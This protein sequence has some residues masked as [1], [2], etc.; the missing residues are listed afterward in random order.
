MD[1]AREQSEALLDPSPAL[2]PIDER[3]LDRIDDGLHFG[4]S[5]HRYRY[6]YRRSDGLR[7]LDAGCGTG[8]SSLGL[9]RLN[10]GATVLG[11]DVEPAALEVARRRAEVAGV[12]DVAFRQHDLRQPLAGDDGPFDFVVCRRVLGRAEDPDRVLAHLARVLDA[13]GLLLLTLPAR[14][15][16]GPVH[17]LRQAIGAL[18]PAGAELAE[19]AAVGLELFAALRPDHP[20]RQF[21]ARFSGAGAPT[22]ARIIA[23]YLGPQEREWDLAEAAAL[24]E[25]AGLRFLYAA[26][27]HPWLPD[28]VFATPQVSES[29]RARVA[30]LSERDQAVLIDALD[31]TMH[32]E[33]YRIYAAPADFEPHLPGW[34]ERLAAEPEVLDRLIP[35][36][37]GVIEPA[38]LAPDP[39][40]ARGQASYR[41]VTG[42]IG[43]VDR[44]ADLMFR[45]VDGRRTVGQID[46]ALYDQTGMAESREVRQARWLDLAGLGFLLLESPDPRQHI[47]CVHLGPVV[48]RLDCPCPRRWVRR[49]ERYEFCSI[50]ET[51]SADPRAE[52]V[53]AARER[54]GIGRLAICAS[55]PD[56][57]PDE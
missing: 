13:R 12:S 43:P 22:A 57:R 41:A 35:H 21:E 4:W 26:A 8:L 24:V 56:Y 30:G 50:D 19:Q 39:A 29:L 42:A 54:L 16:R 28:R 31:P 44:R 46:Q 25:R 47:P 18:A 1:A 40:S 14:G 2:V 38:G 27:H 11:V 17:Q 3:Q 32:L 52:V 34:P 7:I 6:C 9:A 15:G 23:G 20:I 49:C 45:A 36:R 37:T 48:D 33:E 5:W 10:P 55:C 53:A 51:G